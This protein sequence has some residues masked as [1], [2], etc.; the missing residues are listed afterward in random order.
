[1]CCLSV[2]VV[3]FQFPDVVEDDARDDWQS[4]DPRNDSQCVSVLPNNWV[5]SFHRNC[6]N[7]QLL[8]SLHFHDE[9]KDREVVDTI[10]TNDSIHD[11]LPLALSTRYST[12][13]TVVAL[14]QWPD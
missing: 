8:Q 13:L 10:D 2:K 7:F 11:A 14:S 1:M 9:V 3:T 12:G 6:V 4:V 5:N